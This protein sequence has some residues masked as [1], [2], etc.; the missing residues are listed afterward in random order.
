MDSIPDAAIACHRIAKRHR[1]ASMIYLYKYLILL[2]VF[3]LPAGAQ[4]FPAKAI[5][6]VVP[7]P[8]GGGVDITARIIGQKLA[9]LAAQGLIAAPSTPEQFAIHIKQDYE[10]LVTVIKATG[11]KPN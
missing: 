3:T 2:F 1:H 4:S 10:Q 11:I 8:P 9:E 5:R 6:L 7:Y